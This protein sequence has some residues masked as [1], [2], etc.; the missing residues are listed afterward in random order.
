MD[1]RV[2]RKDGDREIWDW[3]PNAGATVGEDGDVTVIAIPDA[4][5]E[6]FYGPGQWLSF[7]VRA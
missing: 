5:V 2:R 1:T 3:Y 7:E 4:T 6:A